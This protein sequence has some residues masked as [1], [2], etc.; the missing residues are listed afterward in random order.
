MGSS[1]ALARSVRGT[2]LIYLQS[3]LSTVLAALSVYFVSTVL[4]LEDYG[5]VGL[6]V[7]L[8]N[9]LIIAGSM[10]LGRAAIHFVSKSLGVGD[11][12]K[13]RGY[14]FTVIKIELGLSSAILAAFLAASH[15]LAATLI[16]RE[17]SLMLVQL[18]ALTTF[19]IHNATVGRSL[20]LG[21]K[22]YEKATVVAALQTAVGPLLEIALA[23]FMGMKVLGIIVAWLI[24]GAASFAYAVKEVVP[25]VLGARSPVELRGL[26][27][28]ALPLMLHSLIFVVLV[29]ADFVVLKLMYPGEQGLFYVGVMNFVHNINGV[30]YLMI[31]SLLSVIFPEFSSIYATKGKE[32]VREA[33]KKTSKYVA[34]I[35]LPLSF[36]F[37]ALSRPIY[38]V[39]LR[40]EYAVGAF[41]TSLLLIGSSLFFLRD[42]V[43]NGYSSIG[44]SDKTLAGGAVMVATQLAFDFILIPG[45][46]VVGATIARVVGAAACFA[47]FTAL[48]SRDG[49]LGVDLRAYA[50]GLASSAVMLAA[51]YLLSVETSFLWAKELVLVTLGF[52]GAVGVAIYALTIKLL[53][54]FEADDWSFFQALFPERMKW[55][56]RKLFNFVCS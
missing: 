7:F 10:G 9:V 23:Y 26:F 36:A 38:F 33:S 37:A 14:A 46:G 50:K 47:F 4:D 15:V 13:A 29:Q 12:K 19:F 28:Y 51:L 11:E 40:P 21:Y 20:L 5:V 32:G 55:V 35:Y 52:Y 22:E 27:R 34:L 2:A 44:E 1:S 45:Y 43:A 24:S 56:A 49:I 30:V 25:K 17:S 31:L 42:I 53:R 41:P 3:I 6:L 18:T 39:V 16:Q 48:A 54:A 8:M